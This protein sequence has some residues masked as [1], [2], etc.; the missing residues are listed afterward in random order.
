MIQNVLNSR[1]GQRYRRV[2]PGRMIMCKTIFACF[3][4]VDCKSFAVVTVNVDQDKIVFGAYTFLRYQFGKRSAVTEWAIA[5][6]RQG[7]YERYRVDL[8]YAYVLYV[9]IVQCK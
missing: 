6:I 1:L 5:A 2:E 7:Y 4:K 9:R 8:P 3:S